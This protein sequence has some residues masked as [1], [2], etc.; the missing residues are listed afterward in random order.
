MSS[1]PCWAYTKA[2]SRCATAHGSGLACVPCMRSCLGV[3]VPC[4][5]V[6]GAEGPG[7]RQGVTA[8][9]GPTAAGNER[10]GRGTR[11]RS[12]VRYRR[13]EGHATAKP[14]IHPRT[15][16]DTSGASASGM[17]A[18]LVRREM[19]LRVGGWL[20]LT[21]SPEPPE[22]G[23]VCPVG[24]GGALQASDSQRPEM[25]ALVKPSPQPGPESCVGPGNGHCEA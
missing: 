3:N 7:T 8:R 22:T 13:G 5:G 20:T 17:N 12:E 24:W 6:R 21:P 4:P 25:A 14:S 2:W 23:P 18:R 10:A 9:W 19:T 16:L 15:V 11:T 1:R